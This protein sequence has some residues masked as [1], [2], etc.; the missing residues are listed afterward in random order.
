[1]PVP[2]L[3]YLIK[4][5]YGKHDAISRAVKAC[6]D[7]YVSKRMY[8]D[9]RR[10]EP[11]LKDSKTILD[12]GVGM[13]MMYKIFSSRGYQVQG[14]DV[15]D[16]S[17]YPDVRPTIYNGYRLDFPNKNFDAAVL[18]RV[19]HHC[20]KNQEAV[21]CEALRVAKRVFIIE[22][23][24]RNLLEKLIVGFN[25]STANWEWRGHRYRDV[26]TG[27]RRAGWNRCA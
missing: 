21:L 3:C 16:L 17:I 7:G 6:V 20:G 9:Y 10:M 8:D 1:M 26:E 14:V 23:V 25:D 13:G 19:L 22:D 2:A 4:N 15:T 12:I 24:Y 11:Y 18:D 27:D 5:R